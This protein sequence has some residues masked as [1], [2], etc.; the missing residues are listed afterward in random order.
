MLF[1]YESRILYDA[2]VPKANVAF[3]KKEIQKLEA[4]LPG[5]GNIATRLRS[6]KE[7]YTIPLDKM[8][9]IMQ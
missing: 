6:M 4:L 7:K 3:L 8:D 1:E 5:N 2:F 9:T